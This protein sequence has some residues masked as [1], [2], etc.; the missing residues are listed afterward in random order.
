MAKNNFL[1]VTA[2]ISEAQKA[3]AGTSKSLTNIRNGVLRIAGS[4]ALK[5]VKE[6][7]RGSGLK[8]RTGE[9]NKAYIR[10]VNTRKGEV[11]LYPVSLNDRKKT[12]FSKAQALSYGAHKGN[13]RLTGK[14]FVQ[15]GWSAV[16]WDGYQAEVEKY[17]DKELKKYWSS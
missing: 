3:L 14:G 17:I 15:K 9:L 11:N 5:K 13:W 10:K 6:A 12:I 1:T 2:D 4:Y 7:I 8:K 16:E